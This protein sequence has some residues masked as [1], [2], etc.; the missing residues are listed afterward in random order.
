MVA[1]PGR[2]CSA[3]RFRLATSKRRAKPD[4]PDSK[5]WAADRWSATVEECRHRTDC[6]DRV[7]SD[8]ECVA[9]GYNLR[10][11]STQGRCPECGEGV[12]RSIRETNEY[13]KGGRRPLFW[14]SLLA[15]TIALYLPGGLFL[16]LL[17]DLGLRVRLL[18]AASSPL[19][20]ALP[21]LL[22][23]RSSEFPA[24]LLTGAILLSATLPYLSTRFCLWLTRRTRLSWIVPIGLL[25]FVLLQVLWSLAVII[26][27][28]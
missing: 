26:S 21:L 1:E 5:K 3:R 12:A 28:G 19:P 27:A 24:A 8:L 10:T 6:E 16:L 14:R 15:N 23:C 2:A 11:L 4:S 18:L 17:P 9:C 13:G 22:D 20:L 25:G 7:A